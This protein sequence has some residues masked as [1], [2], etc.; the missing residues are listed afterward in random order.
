[1]LILFTATDARKHLNASAGQVCDALSC[2]REKL[3]TEFGEFYMSAY[4]LLWPRFKSAI[5]AQ[6]ESVLSLLRPGLSEILTRP[7]L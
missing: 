4:T 6:V 3:G 2:D 5:D 1:M 7:E